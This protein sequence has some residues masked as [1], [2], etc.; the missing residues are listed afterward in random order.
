[1]VGGKYPPILFNYHGH[2]SS[3]TPWYRR[4]MILCIQVLIQ[5]IFAVGHHRHRTCIVLANITLKKQYLNSD[6][7]VSKYIFSQEIKSTGKLYSHS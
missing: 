5:S 1:M 7:E 4:F 2:L 6:I 3:L